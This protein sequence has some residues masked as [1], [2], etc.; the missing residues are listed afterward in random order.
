[1]ASHWRLTRQIPVLGYQPCAPN[2]QEKRIPAPATLPA[3]ASEKKSSPM[4]L[5]SR[6]IRWVS[7]NDP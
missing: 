2:W 6:T 3:V 4:A 5:G 7:T 1:M